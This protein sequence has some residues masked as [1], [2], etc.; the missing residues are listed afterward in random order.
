M[1]YASKR[2]L[3]YALSFFFGTLLSVGYVLWASD[4]VQEGFTVESVR[5]SVSFA[6]GFLI[7]K[8]VKD[9]RRQTLRRKNAHP[10]VKAFATALFKALPWVLAVLIAIAIRTGVL[11]LF[12]HLIVFSSLQ[13]VGTFFFGFEEYYTLLEEGETL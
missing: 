7:F 1:T 10:G 12:F 5:T 2:K 13:I 9:F 6:I 11:N 4:I 8:I 3:A